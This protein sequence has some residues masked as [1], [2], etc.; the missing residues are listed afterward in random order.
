MLSKT[1]NYEKAKSCSL[2]SVDCGIFCMRHMENYLREGEKWQSG[3]RPND[4]GSL[5]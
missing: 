3:F 1:R 2:Q 5:S 4:L